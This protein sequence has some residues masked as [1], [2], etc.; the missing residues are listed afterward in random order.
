MIR[1]SFVGKIPQE[2]LH[3]FDEKYLKVARD[4]EPLDD[5]YA[6]EEE[7]FEVMFG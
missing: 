5:Y 7:A 2:V 4:N 1:S 3:E 6:S